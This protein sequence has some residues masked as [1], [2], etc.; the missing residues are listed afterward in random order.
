MPI[1][2]AG[3]PSEIL[4]RRPDI[5]QAEL[6]LI[7]A[8]ARIGAAKALYYPSISLTGLFGSVSNSFDTLFTGPA[9]LY[10]YGAAV[11]GPIFTGGG[12]SGQV[13]VAEARQQ[14]SLL[15]YQRAIRTAFRDVENALIASQK[16]REA[17]A[18]QE[19]RVDAMRDY[20]RLANLRYDNGYSGYLEVLDAERGLFSAELDYT[21]A[22]S[23]TYFALVDLYTTMGGGWVVDAA[24]LAAQPHVDMSQDPKSFP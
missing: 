13:S 16:S 19:E 11:A 10:S 17:L 15:A 2:P 5:K 1:V 12:I 9:E 20:A 23:D 22:K 3:L 18:A 6:N 14:Q 4:E 24:A 21:Q 8:N 7:A